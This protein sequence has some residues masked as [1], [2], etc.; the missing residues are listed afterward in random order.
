[1]TN[2]SLED[3]CKIT[4]EN[5]GKVAELLEHAQAEADERMKPIIEVFRTDKAQD[6]VNE[7][8][9]L[10]TVLGLSPTDNLDPHAFSFLNGHGLHPL[11][12][13]VGL[14]IDAL[15]KDSPVRSELQRAKNAIVALIQKQ[16]QAKEQ[17]P[18]K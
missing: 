8:L 15:P 16:E 5:T 2:V 9:A 7:R 17:K 10:A 4:D 6:T 11:D 13:H 14:F 12:F 1:M 18:A 3:Y